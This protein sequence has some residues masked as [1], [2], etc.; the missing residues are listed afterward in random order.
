MMLI[1]QKLSAL[2]AQSVTVQVLK[3]LDSVVPGQWENVRDLDTMIMRA[4]GQSSPGI[5][6]DIRAKMAQMEAQEPERFNRALWLFETID[7]VD[8]VAAGAT[9]ASKVTDLFGGLDFMK[10]FTPKPETTQALDAGLKLVAEVLAFGMMQGMPKMDLEGVA[11]FVVALGKYGKADAMRLASWVIIDGMLP[12]GPDFM[13]R[14]I[15]TVQDA[16]NSKLAGHS[17]FDAIS[18]YLPG[19]STEQKQAFVAKALNAT[20][21]FMD[22][23]VKDKGL[24]RQMVI[25]KL[26]GV[27]D[28]TE[29][30][31]DYVAAGLDA[32]TSYFTHTGTQS[33]ARVMAEQAFA[34]LKD[35]VWQRYLSERG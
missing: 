24:N 2:P 3:A 10:E 17:I 11:M 30:T 12:L 23:F 8:K 21:D 16:S 26:S 14:I 13:Q 28:I 15:A 4:T 32:S 19:D 34:S 31:L 5:V 18:S 33:V 29:S 22:K 35:E 7:T 1:E 25:G 6:A 9:V 20:S 27:V